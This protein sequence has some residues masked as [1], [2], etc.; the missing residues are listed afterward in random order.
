MPAPQDLSV[1]PHDRIHTLF[2][3][4][5][6]AFFDAVK[7]CFCGPAKD[8]KDGNVPQAGNPVV[9][10][11]AGGHEP[12]IK[13]QDH[14]QLCAVERNL[15]RGHWVK[16]YGGRRLCIHPKTLACFGPQIKAPLREYTEVGFHVT[17]CW[18]GEEIGNTNM[19]GVTPQHRAELSASALLEKDAASQHLGMSL[20]SVAPGEAV[21][22]MQVK[23]FMLNGH[24]TCHG[25]FLFAFAD[26]AFAVACNSY[27]TKS[28][29]QQNQITYLAPCPSQTVLTAHAL[30][31]ARSGRSGTYDVTVTNE[32]GAIIALMRGLCRDVKGQHFTEHGGET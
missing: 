11:F 32:T 4:Q 12:A 25:G 6:W 27:N 1:H 16:I 29:A 18:Q 3:P 26:S 5:L 21:L 14:R 20:I 22:S 23:D 8:R 19:T 9:P 13:R 30:E 28:V 2:V 15:G 10:P 17:E 7:R 31:T 24:G